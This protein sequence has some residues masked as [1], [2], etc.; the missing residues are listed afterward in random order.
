M[1]AIT[2]DAVVRRR[3]LL[4]G[5][6]LLAAFTRA[7][8]AS[9]AEDAAGFPVTLLATPQ[10]EMRAALADT[11]RRR[12]IGYRDISHERAPGAIW[13][14][15]PSAREV[16]FDMRD[17]RF[18]VRAYWIGQDNCIAGWS[19]MRPGDGGHD[20]PVAVIAV[21]EVPLMEA[22]DRRFQRGDC[23]REK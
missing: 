16:T 22:A 17:V 13:F 2:V 14:R 6:V 11:A 1:G 10:G 23:I 20:S 18:P 9:P 21:L 12:G 4:A 15:Y 5:V 8:I 3:L 19:D 7:I